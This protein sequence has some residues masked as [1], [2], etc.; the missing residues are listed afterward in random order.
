M[1]QLYTSGGQI[2]G[3]SALA[4]VLPMNIQARFPLGLT[5][6]ISLLSKG[7]SRVFYSTTVQKPQLF[8]AQPSLWV[9]HEHP[10]MTTEETIALIHLVMDL[11]L[12]N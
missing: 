2:I 7:L 9:Q 12:Q 1:S 8:G 4:P 11:C 5:G 3:A 10:Y 6:L